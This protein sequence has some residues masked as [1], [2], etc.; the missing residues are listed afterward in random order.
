VICGIS[1][2]S[3]S[4]LLI[5]PFS[6][7]PTELTLAYTLTLSVIFLL[8]T[9]FLRSRKSLKCYWQIFFGFSIASLAIFFD[10]LVNM[11]SGTMSGLVLDMLISTSIIVSTIILLTRVS[12]NSFSAIFLK[13]GNIKLGL[14]FGFTGFFF[15]ALTSIPAAQYLFQRSKSK[16]RQSNCLVALDN[17]YCSAKWS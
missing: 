5:F 16:L 17:T 9:I 4:G 7:V 8:I 11:P 12:G 13:K 10:F 2:P 3:L 14:I 6:A 15:F 1:L